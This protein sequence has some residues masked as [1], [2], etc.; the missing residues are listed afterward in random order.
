MPKSA[1]WYKHQ[2]EPI[3]EIKEANIFSDLLSKRIEKKNNDD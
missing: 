2:I 3:T 1:K